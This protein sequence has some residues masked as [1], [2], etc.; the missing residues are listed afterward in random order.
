MP[1]NLQGRHIRE[2]GPRG[3][4]LVSCEHGELQR[5]QRLLVCSACW[6]VAEVDIAA[7]RP[8]PK[9]SRWRESSFAALSTRKPMAGRW[10]PR[11][12]YG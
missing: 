1:G 2:S 9:R 12:V 5:P 11:G 3:A 8:V 10:L 6:S 4:V 7:P